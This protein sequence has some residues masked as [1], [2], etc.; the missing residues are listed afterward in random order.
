MFSYLN[1]STVLHR[2][3]IFF[4]FASCLVVVV[5]ASILHQFLQI[6]YCCMHI[7]LQQVM[8][9]IFLDRFLFVEKTS[10]MLQLA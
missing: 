4:S 10:L 3:G 7:Y 5:N 2:V 9:K 8:H 6:I 1:G